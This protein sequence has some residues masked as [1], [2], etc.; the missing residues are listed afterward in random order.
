MNS[1]AKQYLEIGLL[2]ASF[3]LVV[4]G[5]TIFFQ[6]LPI[7]NTTLAMDW[8]TEWGAMRGGNLHYQPAEGVRFPPWSLLPF[9]PLGL[10]PMKTAWGILAG[11]SIYL[12]AASVPRIQPTRVYLVSVLLAV[13]SFAS[14]RNIVDGNFEAVVVAGVALLIYAY[15]NENIALLALGLIVATIKIQVVTLLILILLVYIL[16]AWQKWKW[17]KAGVLT[18]AVI[19]PSLIWRGKDWYIAVFGA[20]YDK[21]TNSIIDISLSAALTRLEVIPPG[22]ISLALILILAITIAVA[23]KTRPSLSHDKAGFFI[24]ASLLLAPYAAG[25]SVLSLLVIGIIPLFQTRPWLVGSLLVFFNL[26]YFWTTEFLYNYQAYYWTS[27]VF[28]TWVILTWR[29]TRNSN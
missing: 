21:Y 8:K 23:W 14:I 11:I 27:L 19:L 7:E 18:G 6:M 2:A 25:N 15:R 22:F 3:L 4:G 28:I 1:P 12:V 16:F 9:L 5:L 24:A 17:L 29:L 26:P 20:N 10:L 13:T